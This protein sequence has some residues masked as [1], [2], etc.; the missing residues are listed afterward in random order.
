VAWTSLNVRNHALATT[1]GMLVDST[2]FAYKFLGTIY[3]LSGN[4]IDSP[5][6]RYLSN[7][8]NIL[9]SYLS[10]GGANGVVT[11]GV[12]SLSGGSGSNTWQVFSGLVN[13]SWVITGAIE[14]PVCLS[15]EMD[16]IP[17]T[18]SSLCWFSISCN[19]TGPGLTFSE[20]AGTTRTVAPAGF[21]GMRSMVTTY[22]IT[23]NVAGYNY[24]HP[25]VRMG[26]G[27]GCTF[28]A[29]AISGE[30]WY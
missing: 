24:A 7:Y 13:V 14:S 23:S 19:G 15:C 5:L 9:S 12:A 17:N 8:Y 29:P 28:Q 27:N 20:V 1:M 26:I 6:T 18:G 4:A 25:V 21:P 3:V 11:G 16:V 10:D 30:I 2:N 22:L